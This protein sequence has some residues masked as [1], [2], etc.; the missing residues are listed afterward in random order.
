MISFWTRAGSATRSVDGFLIKIRMRVGMAD[1]AIARI[2]DV[3]SKDSIGI[4]LYRFVLPT[5]ILQKTGGP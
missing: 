5:Q 1:S 2:T 4:Y 3:V